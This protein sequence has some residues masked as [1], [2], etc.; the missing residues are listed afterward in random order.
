MKESLNR[1]HKGRVQSVE[2]LFINM[3]VCFQKTWGAVRILRRS[4]KR[5][6][7]MQFYG[8]TVG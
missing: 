3:V 8:L 6:Y 1:V 4:Q 5:E 7:Q 2:I